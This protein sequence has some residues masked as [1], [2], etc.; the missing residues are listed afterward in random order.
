MKDATA[1]D[2]VPIVLIDLPHVS[3]R[4]Y[5]EIPH[6]KAQTTAISQILD[7]INEK[8]GNFSHGK[9]TLVGHSYGTVVMSWLVQSEPDRIGGCVFLGMF[10]PCFDLFFSI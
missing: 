4:M 9:A 10:S 6:I 3:L 2:N 7:D 1:S 8:V 5:D